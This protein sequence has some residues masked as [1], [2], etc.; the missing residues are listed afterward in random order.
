MKKIKLLINLI[1][2]LSL[3]MLSLNLFACKGYNTYDFL[4]FNSDVQV[5]VD[6]KLKDSIVNEITSILFE[7]ENSISLDNNSSSIKAL[8]DV[9]D[10]DLVLLDEHSF[11]LLKQA[12]YCHALTGGKFNPAVLPLLDLWKLSSSTYDANLSDY[13][14]PSEQEILS[15]LPICDFDNVV[16]N[17]ELKL[18]NK[19]NPSTKIHFGAS[20]KG[21]AVDKI[22]EILVRENCNFG[23]INIGGSSVSVLDFS[24]GLYIRHPKNTSENI[25]KVNADII[26]NSPLSTSGDYVKY[27]VDSLGKRYSHIIDGNSGYPISTGFHSVTI[28]A[29]E[30]SENKSACFTDMISTSLMLTEKQEFIDFVNNNLRGFTVFAV[31]DD[32]IITNAGKNYYSILDSDYSLLEF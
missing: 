17:E 24:D 26:K 10:N 4:C 16:L 11:Y 20:A 7:I 27:Y 30:A 19:L 2:I 8:N 14:P 3:S 29:N 5:V 1:L 15:L 21:Y 18:A 13:S 25:I 9:S 12:K 23:F 6:K 22:K 31:Y 28:I 32:Q